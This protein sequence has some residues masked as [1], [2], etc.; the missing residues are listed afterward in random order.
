MGCVSA[1]LEKVEP[2]TNSFFCTKIARQVEQNGK[3][4]HQKKK[5]R[6]KNKRRAIIYAA[7][8]GRHFHGIFTA[9][10]QKGCAFSDAFVVTFDWQII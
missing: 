8:C 7:L 5:N 2:I 10:I 6:N 1:S 3:V 9:S 4:F